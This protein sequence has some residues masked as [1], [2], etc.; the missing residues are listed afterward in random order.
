MNLISE[1]IRIFH[2]D[3]ILFSD[4]AQLSRVS[5]RFQ[6]FLNS[7]WIKIFWSQ[8]IE[9]IK[10]AP[11]NGGLQLNFF[12]WIWDWHT[13]YCAWSERQS[14]FWVGFELFQAVLKVRDK[15][16]LK[17][18]SPWQFKIRHFALNGTAKIVW[19]NG[20]SRTKLDYCPG[21]LSLAD[22]S[23]NWLNAGRVSNRF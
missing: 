21:N 20:F 11:V 13:A 23:S 2:A 4:S 14:D 18:L 15:N 10:N 22:R 6:F 9:H 19:T 3:L 16:A 8:G 1:I 12:N 5:G 17:R 7:F